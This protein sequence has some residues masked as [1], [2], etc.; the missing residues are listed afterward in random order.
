MAYTLSETAELAAQYINT[1]DKHIFLTG[2]AGTGK[3]TFLKHIIRNTH[4]KCVVAAPTGIAAI[5]AEGVTL[6]SLLQLPFGAFIPQRIHPPMANAKFTT[7]YNL[8]KDVRFAAAKRNLLRE[9]ELLIID[10]VSMLRADLLDCIDHTLRFLRRNKNQPFGGLQILF[11]GDLMQL[12]P[13]V[14]DDE[15]QVLSQYYKSS[16]FFDA[17]AL[18]HERPIHIELKKIYRQQDENFIGILNRFRENHQTSGD[19]KTLNQHYK[20]DYEKL[21]SQGYIH[22]TTH[23]RKADKINSE[24]LEKLSGRTYTY[25]ANIERDYAE[26]LYPVPASLQLKKGAQVMFI[27]NDSSGEGQFFNGKIGQVDSLDSTQIKVRFED[28]TIVTVPHYTWENKRYSLNPDT[29]EIEEKVLGSF[30]HFP[31]RLAWAITVHKSQGLTFEK[32]ILDLTNAFTQGQVYVALS[33]MTSLKGLVLSSPIPENGFPISQ[34]ME[35]FDAAKEAESVIASKLAQEQIEYLKKLISTSFDFTFF[36]RSLN[37]HLLSFDK[38]ENRSL[39]QQ[40][41]AWTNEQIA[42]LAPIEKIGQTFIRQGHGLLSQ[43]DPEL[44]PLADRVT[45][46]TDYFS[47]LL[48]NFIEAVNTHDRGLKDKTKIKAYR[49]ELKT[50]HELAVSIH[51]K[52]HKTSLLVSAQA[53]GETLTKTHVEEADF[54]KTQKEAVES[55]KKKD[56][57]PTAEVSFA[58]HKAGKSIDEIAEERQLVPG[59]IASHLAKYVATG[60]VDAYDLVDKEKLDNILSLITPQTAGSGEIKSKLGDDYSWEEVRFG[61]AQYHRNKSSDAE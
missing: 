58:L 13:V 15:W 60:E 20:T 40:Y 61:M 54:F 4:K 12:P 38:Q 25:S 11:I 23:N 28:D 43:G 42:L 17:L 14:K 1:T 49:K 8:F 44:M 50:L 55:Q 21:S 32:A 3:T 46:A 33:R 16:Y 51:L 5:N 48:S 7:L 41:L 35:D 39:K 56:K 6:H 57:T 59:T 47:E 45:K 52:L 22:L 26:N 24:A 31:I 18:S 36:I 53:K 29:Q 19:L 2:K 10:E 9:V 37:S 27:K 34:A 30:E